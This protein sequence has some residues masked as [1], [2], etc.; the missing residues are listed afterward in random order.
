MTTV[1]AC[2]I[3][4]A[5]SLSGSALAAPTPTPASPCINGDRVTA[6]LD[7]DAR[8]KALGERKAPCRVRF[9]R[10]VYDKTTGWTFCP[11]KWVLD[12]LA[13][14]PAPTPCAEWCCRMPG[15]GQCLCPC[16]RPSPTPTRAPTAT[17]RPT[18]TQP[19]DPL[20]PCQDQRPGWC[21]A[22]GS[23][24]SGNDC[25]ANCKCIR[26]GAGACAE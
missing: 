9:G 25:W 23:R 10:A 14:A 8:C 16:P 22:E 21:W 24:L 18:G 17:P 13:L 3:A 20:A 19:P 4:L 6:V 15:T 1:P 11:A 26:R 7:E 12:R 5:L 2:L